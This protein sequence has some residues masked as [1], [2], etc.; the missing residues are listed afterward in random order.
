VIHGAI[1]GYSRLITFL[2]CSDNNRS[3]TVLDKFTKANQEYGLPS[4]V[5]TDHGGENVLVWD[6]MENQRGYGRSSYI[7]GRSTHN[8]RIER[9]WRDVYRSVTS[10]FV[11]L[12]NELEEIGALSTDNETDMY[13]LHYV[14]IPRINA[15]LSS[16]QLAWNHHPLSTE[17][18]LSPLQLYTAYAQGSSLFDEIEVDPINYGY[19]PYSPIPEEDDDNSVTVVPPFIPL[20]NQSLQRLHSGVNPNSQSTDFGMQLYLDAIQVVYALMLDDGLL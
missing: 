8:T 16:F 18:N 17:N 11:A 13:C 10:S 3:E 12:F 19:D 14:F 5:R 9:L 15:A 6:F 2:Q 7:A 20:S 1:D 4:R